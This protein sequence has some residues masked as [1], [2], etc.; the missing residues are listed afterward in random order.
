MDRKNNLGRAM[1]VTPQCARIDI[2]A[3]AILCGSFTQNQYQ[4]ESYTELGNYS[5]QGWI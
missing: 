3:S 4:N 2:S 1:Y 5:G